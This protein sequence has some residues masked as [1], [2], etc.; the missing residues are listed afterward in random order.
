MRNS[1]LRRAFTLVE[2]LVV[3]AIIGI[4][5]ALL[6]P[7]VQA[8]REAARRMSCSN[9]MKQVSMALHLHNDAK[10][11][12]PPGHYWPEPGSTNL[13]R[14]STWVTYILSYLEQKSI[15]DMIDFSLP[16]A[17][18]SDPG[19]PNFEVV[20]QRIPTMLC[21][22]DKKIEVRNL[23]DRLKWAHGNYVANNGIGPMREV[24]TSDLPIT[25]VKGVFSLNSNTRFRDIT[26]GTS[27]TAMLSELILTKQGM[28]GVMHYPEGALYHYVFTPNPPNPD[29]VRIKS[30]CGNP[31]CTVPDNA[32]C[33]EIY[34]SAFDRQHIISARSMHPGGVNVALVDG[35]IRFVEDE[36]ELDPWRA[37]CTPSGDEVIE[38]F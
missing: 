17:A 34:S 35:S 27:H 6:L 26:D 16:F 33:V 20:A 7:A 13:A 3:I 22:S 9:N 28:R 4:L 8:A 24:S 12:L 25:R 37:L 30:C 38:D 19:Q 11:H 31:P 36:I 21:P 32:P 1:S 23:S 29:Y 5:I 10:G 2:L 14:E 15:G 18:A